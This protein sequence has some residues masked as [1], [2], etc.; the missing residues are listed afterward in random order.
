MF[1]IRAEKKVAHPVISAG[2]D[3]I[4]GDP[5]FV[6]VGH[7]QSEAAV[8]RADVYFAEAIGGRDAAQGEFLEGELVGGTGTVESSGKKAEQ[9]DCR[10]NRPKVFHEPGSSKSRA[11]KTPAK[12]KRIG[13]FPPRGSRRE[14]KAVGVYPIPKFTSGFILIYRKRYFRE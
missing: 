1:A 4:E 13:R 3:A 6:A 7:R 9:P 10:C 5:P 12:S 8:V 14:A 11:A 2:L